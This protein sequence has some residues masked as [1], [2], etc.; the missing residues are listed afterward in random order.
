[1]LNFDFRTKT[2]RCQGCPNRCEV[3]SVFM[4]T[5]EKGKDGKDKEELVARWGDRCGKWAVF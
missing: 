2:F 4:K 5:K 1:M 3:V